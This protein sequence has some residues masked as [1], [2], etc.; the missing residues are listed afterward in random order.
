VLGAM[1]GVMGTLAATEAIR[2][3]SSFG[4]DQAGKLHIMDGLSLSM[5]AIRLP[6]DPAC[7]SCSIPAH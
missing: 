2:I 4:E 3:L 6:K 1:V 7:K 5:R